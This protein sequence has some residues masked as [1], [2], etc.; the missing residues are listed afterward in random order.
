MGNWLTK[1]KSISKQTAVIEIRSER[2][3]LLE[4]IVLNKEEAK[5]TASD[6][7]NLISQRS[8]VIKKKK[9]LLLEKETAK[10]YIW[11]QDYHSKKQV[12]SFTSQDILDIRGE[13]CFIV[14]E[15]NLPVPQKPFVIKKSSSPI[16][17]QGDGKNF[18][19]VF[20]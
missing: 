3:D 1:I 2:N 13:R 10:L 15:K 9:Y 5:Y 8:K 14:A 7:Y 16:P 12:I 6:L 17:L 18:C 19:G 4:T 20:F 11:N